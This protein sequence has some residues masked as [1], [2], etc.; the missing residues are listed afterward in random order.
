MDLR[1]C[2]G[3]PFT[4]SGAG[5]HRTCLR[6][7]NHQGRPA[8]PLSELGPTHP[9]EAR[10]T[11]PQ[12]QPTACVS[13][14]GLCSLPRGRN[15]LPSSLTWLFK[16]RRG[17][18]CWWPEVSAKTGF[19]PWLAQ[20]DKHM[21]CAPRWA[22]AKSLFGPFRGCPEPPPSEPGSS[23]SPSSWLTRRRAILKLIFVTSF[24][25]SPLLSS[26]R[27]P[28]S[29]FPPRPTGILG[30]V[31]HT[32]SWVVRAGCAGQGHAPP[33]PGRVF[34]GDG[35]VPGQAGRTIT[36]L[37]ASGPSTGAGG[38]LR[39]VTQ[40]KSRETCRSRTLQG[41]VDGDECPEPG[42]HPAHPSGG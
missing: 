10:A 39:A 21:G 32:G 23:P 1:L 9:A 12:Q 26:L 20:A 40:Q 8:Q 22:S 34:S 27:G 15:A 25:P 41:H 37:L 6:P 4:P 3:G 42:H 29:S 14:G 11:R 2:W 35:G 17:N 13:C 18:R 30:M 28:Q 38:A 16:Y 31:M 5:R 33:P 19:W 7:E 36:G 24:W